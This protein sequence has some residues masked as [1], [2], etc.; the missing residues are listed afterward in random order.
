MGVGAAVVDTGQYGV[1]P[2]IDDLD[3]EEPLVVVIRSAGPGR[4]IE[5]VGDELGRRL[6]ERG[7]RGG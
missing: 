1:G 5:R 7:V 2:R 6:P 4:R 3:E